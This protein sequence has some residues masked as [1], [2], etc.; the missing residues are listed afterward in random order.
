MWVSRLRTASV[1][2]GR[3]IFPSVVYDSLILT[4]RQCLKVRP[5][6]WVPSWMWTALP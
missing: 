5:A 1:K 2:M 6:L 4:R 3:A